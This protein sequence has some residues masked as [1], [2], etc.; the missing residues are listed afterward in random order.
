MT[1][2]RQV[3]GPLISACDRINVCLVSK[4]GLVVPDF[5][6]ERPVSR[7]DAVP[8]IE[9]GGWILTPGATA[10]IEGASIR[11]VFDV[12]PDQ[13]LAGSSITTITRTRRTISVAWDTRTL[14]Q[15]FDALGDGSGLEQLRTLVPGAEQQGVCEL[16]DALIGWGAVV[17]TAGARARLS[18]YWS[19]RGAGSQAPLSAEEIAEVTFAQ[20]AYADEQGHTVPLAPLRPFPLD[21][22]GDILRRRRSP[23]RYDFSFISQDQLAQLLAGACGVTGELVLGNQRL[24]LRAYPSPGA[25]YG[26]DVYVMATRVEGLVRH[27]YRYDSDQHALVTIPDSKA[28]PASFCLPDVRDVA[29]GASVFIALALS[30]PRA[31]QKYGD[32][33]YRILVAEAG[34]IAENIILVAHALGLSAGPFTGV[35]DKLVDKM[36]GLNSHDSS[37]ALGVLV[38]REARAS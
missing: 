35:F 23:Y 31:L 3:S 22:L 26:V 30:L 11:F 2:R 1:E 37:F 8:G 36:I 33:S 28:D 6:F 21:S 34:C 27:V 38:G 18:M 14:R 32:E 16:V 20:R 10:L 24:D 4:T 25:L 7:A 9:A 29:E 15:I 17:P 5:N 13:V 19:M 12:L